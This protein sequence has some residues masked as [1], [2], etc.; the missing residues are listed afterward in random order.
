MKNTVFSAIGAGMLALAGSAQAVLVITEVNSNANNGTGVNNGDFFEL[1]NFGTGSINLTG[2][3]WDDDSNIPGVSFLPSIS[4][5]PGQSVVFLNDDGDVNL[6]RTTWGLSLAVPVYALSPGYG[7]GGNDI[8]YV[9]DAANQ[10]VATFNYTA[11]G[12]NTP[13]G[14]SVG[15]HAGASAGGTGTQ[16]AIYD[17]SSSP[18]NPLYVA[19]NGTN[20]GSYAAP[21]GNG[22]GSPGFVIPEASTS[23]FA[24]FSL[25]GATL[26]R[27][28]KSA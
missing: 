24:M 7:L 13:T 8:V 11:G 4:I 3:S 27:R 25:L 20:F 18:T 5:N 9:Y 21:N 28:R 16:S 19:A 14:A 17:P 23:A 26:L 2:Y 10:P 1:T 22:V 15:G 6:F 12:F